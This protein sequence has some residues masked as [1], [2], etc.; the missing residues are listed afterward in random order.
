MD[1][2]VKVEKLSQDELQQK[3][4]FDWPM[5]EK[6]VSEF[7][8]SYD[9]IEECYILED[10]VTITP[11]SGE[12]V[13]FGVGDFVTFPKGLNCTWKITSPVKKHYRFS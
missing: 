9:Q 4:V 11:A 8:W 12:P 6:E 13:T 5:W 10:Q 2:H 1:Q 7:P 3:G